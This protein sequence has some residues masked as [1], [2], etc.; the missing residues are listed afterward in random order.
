VKL[1]S[2]QVVMIDSVGN[3]QASC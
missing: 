2:H 3:S 1:L